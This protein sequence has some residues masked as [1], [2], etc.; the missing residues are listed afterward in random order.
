MPVKAREGKER[1]PFFTPDVLTL[2][3]ELERTR[4][5]KAFSDGARRLARLL[6]LT[7]EFWTGNTPCDRS[8]SPSH[9]PHCQAFADWHVCRAVRLELL[10]AIER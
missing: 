6:N 5:G 7:S 2:F 8:R 4:E 9:P 1:R 10:A 3:A